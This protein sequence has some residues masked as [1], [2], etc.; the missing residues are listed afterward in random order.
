MYIKGHKHSQETK[1]KIG[2]ANKGNKRPDLAAFNRKR[3]DLK[4]KPSWNKGM[5]TPQ[6]GVKKGNIPWNQGKHWSIETRNKISIAR[7]GKGINPNK[8][9]I[10]GSALEKWRKEVI[11]RD[12]KCL[13]CGSVEC[14][15]AHHILPK[16][17]YPDKIY[18]L[19][20][21]MTL[22][23]KCHKRTNTYGKRLDLL[24]MKQ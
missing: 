12:K 9:G 19:I 1:L 22:C 2:K 18:D 17:L 21:G 13:G 23:K 14:L 5:K 11:E 15:E 7:K 4:G 24:K 10:N 3:T 6:C 8:V 16:A 20:N